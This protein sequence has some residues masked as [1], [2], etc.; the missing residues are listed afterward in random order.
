LAL[1]GFKA[2]SPWKPTGS[3]ETDSHSAGCV[4]VQNSTKISAP[5]ADILFYAAE[6][7]SIDH[8]LVVEIALTLGGPSA[9]ES[10]RV[11]LAV[12]SLY[13]MNGR[14]VSAASRINGGGC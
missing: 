5:A 10:E 13:R 11:M 2:H 6:F 8:F 4:E 7:R 14:L 3:I 12:K 9:A 1:T